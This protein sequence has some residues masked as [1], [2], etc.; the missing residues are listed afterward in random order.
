M[1]MRYLQQKVSNIF[2]TYQN[3]AGNTFPKLFELVFPDTKFLLSMAI[4]AQCL[5]I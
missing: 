2:L 5:C 3:S 1:I 4:S